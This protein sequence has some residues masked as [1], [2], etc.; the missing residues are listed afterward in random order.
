MLAASAGELW[1]QLRAF[2]P[3]MPGAWL[4]SEHADRPSSRWV[5]GWA[6]T[7]HVFSKVTVKVI[8]LQFRG[9]DAYP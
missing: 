7:G 5:D 9:S 8:Y 6:R 1:P 4:H 2:G 3:R